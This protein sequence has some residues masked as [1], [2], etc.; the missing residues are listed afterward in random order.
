MW[1]VHNTVCM[2]N[3]HAGVSKFKHRAVV[4]ASDKTLIASLLARM[5]SPVS[6][7]MRIPCLPYGMGEPLPC[8]CTC[9]GPLCSLLCGRRRA[10]AR[11]C[12]QH[13]MQTQGRRT[14][15]EKRC[16]KTCAAC[17]AHARDKRK[18]QQLCCSVGG[19]IPH[20]PCISSSCCRRPA[21]EDQN[22]CP[23]L[24]IDNETSGELNGH[25]Q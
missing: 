22:A 23:C 18:H 7:V 14:S 24:P 4:H 12:R 8:S 25:K 2:H 15:M 11:S 9:T 10:C 20:G 3:R 5:L 6:T 1:F 19:G 13:Q 17:N 16:T 21:A